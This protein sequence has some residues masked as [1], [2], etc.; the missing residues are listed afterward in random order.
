VN[1]EL[2][3]ASLKIWDRFEK[4]FGVDIGHRRTGSLFLARDEVA[5]CLRLVVAITSYERGDDPGS[6]VITV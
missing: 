5:L 3:L 4:A 6:T 1:V 2:S